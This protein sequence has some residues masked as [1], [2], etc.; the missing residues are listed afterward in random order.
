MSSF[1][2]T[3]G[4]YISWISPGQNIGVGSCSLLQGIFPTQGRTQ[5]SCISGGFVNIKHLPIPLLPLVTTILL[6]KY[7]FIWLYLGLPWWF[8]GK[9]PACNAGDLNSIPGLGRAPGEV[10]GNALQDSC[11]E[12]SMDSGVGQATIHVVTNSKTRLSR[13]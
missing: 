8:S 13:T 4:L 2:R 6:F 1:L 7:L 11:L 3:H 5:V 10:N 12:N 9:E